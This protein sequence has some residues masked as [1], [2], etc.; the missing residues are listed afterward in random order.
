MKSFRQHL[1]EVMRR[2]DSKRI[3]VKTP[4]GNYVWRNVKKEV[5]V[6]PEAQQES[7]NL[8]GVEIIMGATKNSQEAEKEVA[9]RM[10]VS[11]AQAKKLVQQVMKRA[12]KGKK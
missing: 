7:V 8:D 6:E 10:K 5:K 12:H 3:K 4:E 2:A 9:K 1:E 11:A